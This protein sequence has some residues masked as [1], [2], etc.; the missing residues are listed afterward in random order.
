MTRGSIIDCGSPNH[1][2]TNT[3]KHRSL[4]AVAVVAVVVVVVAVVVE[5]SRTLLASDM[6]PPVL[7]KHKY[8]S[9]TASID[10]RAWHRLRSIWA[11]SLLFVLAELQDSWEAPRPVTEKSRVLTP[12]SSTMLPTVCAS[13]HTRRNSATSNTGKNSSVCRHTSRGNQS[14]GLRLANSCLVSAWKWEAAKTMAAANSLFVLSM[15]GHLNEGGDSSLS[16]LLA[17]LANQR[18]ER[19]DAR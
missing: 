11:S 9:P 3:R 4:A 15:L 16:L 14:N 6:S 7:L 5:N 1:R 8:L 17:D 13:L 18:E 10:V 19:L 12:V 2:S